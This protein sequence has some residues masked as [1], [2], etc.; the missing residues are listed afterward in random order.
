[1]GG[2]AFIG[3]GLHDEKGITLRGLEEARGADVVFLESYTSALS[4]TTLASIEALVGK[5]IRKVS[6]VAGGSLEPPLLR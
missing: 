5:Q 1:M 2:L 6:R 3:L 4:G